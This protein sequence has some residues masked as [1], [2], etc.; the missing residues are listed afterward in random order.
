[1]QPLN[2]TH[3]KRNIYHLERKLKQWLLEMKNYLLVP[4]VLSVI[5]VIAAAS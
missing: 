3:S 5:V 4:F 1:M 2:V